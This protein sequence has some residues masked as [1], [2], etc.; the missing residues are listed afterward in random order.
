MGYKKVKCVLNQAL[1]MINLYVLMKFTVHSSS[2]KHVIVLKV[3]DKWTDGY[4]DNL[5]TKPVKK[6]M[7]QQSCPLFFSYMGYISWRWENEQL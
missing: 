2:T 3:A 6:N 7:K 5:L 1:V 4:D